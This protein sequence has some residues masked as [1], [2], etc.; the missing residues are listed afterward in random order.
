MKLQG[1]FQQFYQRIQ[2][3]MSK[4]QVLC[5]NFA[6]CKYLIR[7]AIYFSTSLKETSICTGWVAILVFQGVI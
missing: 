4:S 5:P 1:R 2:V 7:P 3:L 6:P